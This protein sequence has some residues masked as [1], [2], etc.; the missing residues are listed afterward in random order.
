M[1]SLEFLWISMINALFLPYFC[2][3]KWTLP[4]SPLL[5]GMAMQCAVCKTAFNLDHVIC[6]RS[7][8]LPCCILVGWGIEDVEH[9]DENFY[10]TICN[11]GPDRKLN[12]ET[13]IENQSL[14]LFNVKFS[15]FWKSKLFN[16]RFSAPGGSLKISEQS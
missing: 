2:P 10:E 5:T 8:L 4:I 15:G 6:W 7:T 13:W 11:C 9:Q 16:V 12:G 1:I 14:V 3:E